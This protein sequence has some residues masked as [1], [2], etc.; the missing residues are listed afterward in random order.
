MKSLI[1][2]PSQEM[3]KSMFDYDERTG[4]LSW[5]FRKD[6]SSQWNGRFGGKIAGGQ[7]H[8]N[9]YHV[10][11]IKELGPVLS[12]RVI[13]K[14]VNGDE[15]ETV[16][17]IDGNG[18]NNKISNLRAATFAQ[19]MRNKSPHKG[20]LL[21]KGVTV[22]GKSNKFRASICVNRKQIHLGVFVDAEMAHRAYS[23]AANKL[24][25]E[26]ARSA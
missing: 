15:P 12:H 3:L 2:L 4:L 10:L 8:L 13:W 5:R 25:G 9:G 16:D 18:S 23:E 19:N 22:V 7:S 11:V 1:K 14:W 26:F 17:H 6:R 21:P 24:F 20:K